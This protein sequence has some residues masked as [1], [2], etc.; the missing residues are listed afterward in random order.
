MKAI[1][2]STASPSLT[3]VL[4][5]AGEDNVILRTTEGRQY[6]LAEIDDFA[7]EVAKVGQNENLMRLLDERSEETTQ[8]SLKEV[9]ER[10][11]G[12]KRSPGKRQRK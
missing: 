6:L 9:R 1:D 4:K 7:D 12:K 5:L 8:F 11:Q 10:L 3:E 2:L